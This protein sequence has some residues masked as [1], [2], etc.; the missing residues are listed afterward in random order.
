MLKFSSLTIGYKLV[1]LFIGA[2][3]FWIGI[4]LSE[5]YKDRAVSTK[6]DGSWVPGSQLLIDRRVFGTDLRMEIMAKESNVPL[7]FASKINASKLHFNVT[8]A[9]YTSPFEISYNNLYWQVQEMKSSKIIYYMYGAYFDRRIRTAP[10]VHVVAFLTK[11]ENKAK[12]PYCQVWFNKKRKPSLVKA[13]SFVKLFLDGP[14]PHKTMIPYLVTCKIPSAMSGKVPASVSLV[15]APCEK[16]TNNLRVIYNPLP[17][18]EKKKDFLV[19]VKALF[20]TFK[21]HMAVRIVEWIE[22]LKILGAQK[23]VIYN[24]QTHK[25]IT[26]VLD[27]YASKDDFEVVPVTLP[28]NYTNSPD[29]VSDFLA[30]DFWL[31]YKNDGIQLTDCLYRN[32]YKFKYVTALDIDEVIVP[33]K[34]ENWHDLVY[35]VAVPRAAMQHKSFDAFVTRN[36]YFMDDQ[37]ERQAWFPDVPPY[38]HMLQNVNRRDFHNP[39]GVV[40]HTVS[41]KG[42]FDVR[43]ILFVYC[44]YPLSCVNKKCSYL[45]FDPSESQLQHYC[46]GQT[47]SDCNVTDGKNI[48]Q[49]VSMWKYKDELVGKTNDV[50][51]KTGFLK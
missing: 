22:L 5:N 37:I 47:K 44:H 7:Q 51:R 39:P 50:L 45:T 36:T 42:F 17:A 32:L 21:P 48:V 30:E 25:N 8:C 38:M 13:T 49:D 19:C 41:S 29:L 18:G 26:R 2:I 6:F 24:F 20:L 23:I 10:A 15:E 35:E 27:Y 40:N 33:M 46:I 14:I 34:N 11:L 1:A 9:N 28:A 4:M 43:K 16:A 12:R 31:Q 3:I